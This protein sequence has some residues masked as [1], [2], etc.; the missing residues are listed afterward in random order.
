MTQLSDYRKTE[1]R[2]LDDASTGTQRPPRVSIKDNKFAL[3]D[4]SGTRI[5]IP[6]L[7]EGPA[8]D[9][10]FVDRNEKISKLFWR[11]S[12]N[13]NEQA[14]PV[15]FSDNGVAPSETAAEPQSATCMTCPHNII[16]SATS[17]ISGKPIKACMDVK[18]LAVIVVKDGGTYDGVFLL[19][20]K[21]G[22]FK[23]WNSYTN[24][25]RMQ[26]LPEGDRPDLSDVVTRVRFAGQG[27][28]AFDP[29]NLVD[30]DS[31]LAKHVINVWDRNK[32]GD[33]TGMMVGR[34]DPPITEFAPSTAPAALPAVAAPQEQ[35]SEN[36]APP[37]P[38]PVKASPQKSPTST[39]V[40]QPKSISQ[41]ARVT[42]KPVPTA[43][44]GMAE[45][46][47]NL[48]PTEIMRRLDSLSKLPTVK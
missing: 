48:P 4:P 38:P 46:Q 6:F 11:G 3:I 36:P 37:P 31:E 26:K 33:I 17:N 27:I 18:K 25:L 39:Q 9:V 41:R 34:Y 13:E 1:K 19:E 28:L 8:L 21:P 23:A 40:T 43:Q 42:K 10:I 12:Y 30:A 22:S 5:D 47:S 15:C 45:P 16:G 20:I 35:Q 7:P 2:L 24:W 29:T 32:E 44:H 14:P